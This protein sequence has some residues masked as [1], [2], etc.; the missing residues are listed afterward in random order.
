MPH[1]ITRESQRLENG[2]RKIL[3]TLR[4]FVGISPR[5]I[6][7]PHHPATGHAAPRQQKTITS[8]TKR[9]GVE[10]DVTRVRPGADALTEIT[11][12][13]EPSG[14]P[15][16]PAPEKRAHKSG[17]RHFHH[18]GGSGGAKPRGRGR[19]PSSS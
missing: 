11:G 4:R 2:R 6:T 8:L 18:R 19:R 14:V 15:W 10:A 7:R 1:S 3:R 16:Y 13:K 9:A 17:P 12:A 5:G